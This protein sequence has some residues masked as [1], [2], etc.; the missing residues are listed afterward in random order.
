[1]EYNLLS[2]QMVYCSVD[3]EWCLAGFPSYTDTFVSFMCYVMR[4]Q[5]TV[6]GHLGLASIAG[7][8]RCVCL[9][10]RVCVCAP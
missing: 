5:C 9:C 10:A 6:R 7:Q 8:V 4:L 2:T 1:M 3:T